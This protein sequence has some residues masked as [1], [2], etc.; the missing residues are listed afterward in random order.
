MAGPKLRKE[1]PTTSD[2]RRNDGDHGRTYFFVPDIEAMQR[3]DNEIHFLRLISFIAVLLT[4]FVFAYHRYEVS[5]L[6]TLLKIKDEQYISALTGG[7]V[8]TGEDASVYVMMMDQFVS[9]IY[10]IAILVGV[11][12]WCLKIS[13]Y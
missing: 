9:L 4:P 13:E 2:N 1:R 5:Q 6:E 10:I 8:S 3:K 11:I 12:T 7:V